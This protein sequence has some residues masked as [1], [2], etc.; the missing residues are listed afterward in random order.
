MPTPADQKKDFF[1][2]Y[3]KAD[4]DYAE[5]IAWIL[6]SAGYTTVIQ[7][8]D[9]QAGSNFVLEM[10]KATKTARRTIP[11]LSADY[12]AARY[13]APEWAV[14]FAQ[15]PTG[16]NRQVI[17]VRVRDCSLEGLLQPIVYIDLVNLSEADAKDV[18][19]ARIRGGRLKPS[20]PPNFPG[21]VKAETATPVFPGT[22]EASLFCIPQ[23]RNPFFVGRDDLLARISDALTRTGRV[24]L[25]GLGGT[26][27]TETAIEYAFRKNDEYKFVLWT[28][29][30]SNES[31][32]SGLV[33]LAGELFPESKDEKDQTKIVK[34]MHQW[35]R[36]NSDWLLIMDNAD[37]LDVIRS[38]V[39]QNLP[40]HFIVTTRALAT[41]T[42]ADRVEIDSLPADEATQLLLRRARILKSNQTVAEAS[43]ED[44]KLAS[45][46]AND[47]LAGLPLALDQAG[48]YLE[49]TACGLARYEK[50]F[51]EHGMK[52]MERRGALPSSHPDPVAVTWKISFEK[53]EKSNLVASGMLRLAAFLHPD[54]IPEELFRVGAGESDSIKPL[55][56]DDFELEEAIQQV[57]KYSLMRRD[58]RRKTLGMHRLVQMVIQDNMS[59]EE[60]S[61]WATHATSV[62]N[63][64]FPEVEF[65][66]WPECERLMP[67]AETCINNVEEFDLSFE[68]V[69]RLLGL[70]GKYFFERGRIRD[71]ETSLERTLRIL[72]KTFGPDHEELVDGLGA[73]ASVR[74][75]QGRESEEKSLEARRDKILIDDIARDGWGDQPL[76]QAQKVVDTFIT[77]LGPD[78]PEVARALSTLASIQATAD[79][80]DD[81]E[82]SLTRALEIQEGLAQQEPS[83]SLAREIATTRSD[84]AHLYSKQQQFEKAIPLFK[85]VLAEREKVLGEDHPQVAATLTSMGE[86]FLEQEKYG[87]AEPLY[88]RALSID[89]QKLGPEHPSVLV[90][91][92]NLAL[93]CVLTKR[94][95]EA[96][97]FMERGSKICD[98]LGEGPNITDFRKNFE[99][100]KNL[101]SS[102]AAESDTDQ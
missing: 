55:V 68:G 102:N 64:A 16:A 100:L 54:S 60:R 46:I 2:S 51:Q 93:I 73:L 9:F 61:Q 39:E 22:I 101:A 37:D 94:F 24:A 28:R 42:L 15:D 72:E 52:L 12:L 53:A 80:Y 66:H 36:Q 30:D 89:E 11:V 65:D 31:L 45:H 75:L 85:R 29:A 86:A 5:W 27:K 74:G 95:G 33:A 13:T 59:D 7:A 88:Q 87:E 32:V 26:G 4:K 18:L 14:A 50:L 62:V 19:L 91:L 77:G 44:V 48:A 99:Q 70:V 82:K 56:T 96:M 21:V 67:S 47:I 98:S 79:L 43:A 34:A 38:I 25:S 10:D 20:R 58:A 63:T 84:L 69:G 83:E 81:A 90:S 8:W 6:E 40:G 78:R 71:A 57:L 3:N 49:E 76:E 92:L 41:G 35:L 1:I 23:R 17:P 97:V